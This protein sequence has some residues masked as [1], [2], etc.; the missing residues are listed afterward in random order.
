MLKLT[1]KQQASLLSPTWPAFTETILPAPDSSSAVLVEDRFGALPQYPP[2]CAMYAVKGKESPNTWKHRG[3]QGEESKCFSGLS[4][5]HT[6]P[7][8]GY[9]GALIYGHTGIGL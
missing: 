1:N 4:D 5:A 7:C 8:P 9:P 3:Y 6:P 2:P